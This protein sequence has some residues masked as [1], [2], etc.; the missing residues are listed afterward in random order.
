MNQRLLRILGGKTEHY[1]C[2]LESKYPRI[3]DT[4]M[5]LWDEDAID[6]YFTSLMVSDRGERTGFP[7]NVAAEIMHL[8]LVHAAQEPP[9]RRR[10]IWDANSGAFASFTPHP[11]T[12]WSAPEQHLKDALQQHNLSCT[13]EGFFEAVESGNRTATALFLEGKYSTEIRDNRGWT[14]LMMAAF[15]GHDEIA[16]LLLQ[17]N[18]D[19][20]ALDLGGNSALHWAAFGGHLPCAQR[21]IQHHA[22]IDARNNFGWTPL[23]QATARNHPNVV[24]LLISSGANLD[25]AANDGYTALHKAAASGYDEIVRL[26]LAQGADQNLATKNGETPERLSIKNHHKQI[27]ELFRH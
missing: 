1:P 16:G 11:A 2:A 24:E 21:L 4:I 27:V 8:N 19:V 6:E 9:E 12:D 14:P 18:A 26:L 15:A 17:H 23:I 20:N 22:K 3:L 13:P 10:D 7:P 25:A 5:S